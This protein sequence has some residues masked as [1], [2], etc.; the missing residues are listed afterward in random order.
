MSNK[1]IFTLT[2]CFTIV[3]ATL[4]GFL[5]FL[6]S[7]GQDSIIGGTLIGA[8]ILFAILFLWV[9]AYLFSEKYIY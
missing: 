3:V 7:I 2:F 9:M 5:Y 8:S 4:C 6:H 1:R